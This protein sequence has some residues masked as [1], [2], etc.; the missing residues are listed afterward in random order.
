MVAV[1]LPPAPKPVRARSQFVATAYACAG[2]LLFVGTL[3]AIY[4]K[5]RHL[6]GG[7][8]ATWLPKKLK[9]PE[10]P[11]N[12]ML[13]TMVLASISAQWAVYAIRRANRRDASVALG[14]TLLFG[15]AFINAQVFI[16]DQMKLPIRS[17]DGKAF[18]LLFYTTTGSMLFAV[19]IGIVYALVTAFHS[20][21]GRFSPTETDGVSSAA[22]YWHF[23]T[24]AYAAVWFFVYVTK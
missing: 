20:L 1:A 17:V 16:Y 9:V 18:N 24:V 15:L 21:G 14:L 22:L 11:S 3:L 4:M 12:T 5:Q 7:T 23:L 8:T 19:A 2:G 6:A 13:V 10:I